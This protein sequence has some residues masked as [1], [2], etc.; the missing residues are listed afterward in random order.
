MKIRIYVIIALF[1]LEFI[2]IPLFAVLNLRWL[3]SFLHIALLFSPAL[4]FQGFSWKFE[5]SR[6]FVFWAM[7]AFVMTIA[8]FLKGLPPSV[9]MAMLASLFAPLVLPIL[10]D[11]CSNKKEHWDQILREVL[12]II[13]Y[14]GT[15]YFFAEWIVVSRLQLIS[16]CQLASYLANERSSQFCDTGRSMAV[17]FFIYKDMSLAIVMGAFLSFT[18]WANSRINALRFFLLTF[19]MA[20]VDSITLSGILLFLL[21][22]RFRGT[23]RSGLALKLLFVLIT[24]NLFVFSSSYGR[25]IGY[26]INELNLNVFL[27]SLEGCTWKNLFILTDG[28]SQTCHSREMHSLFYLFKFGLMA[29][30]SWYFTLALIGWKFLRTFFVD[31][32]VPPILFF[33]VVFLLNAVHYSGAEGWGV[34]YFMFVVLFLC[35]LGNFKNVSF[36]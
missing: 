29:T 19:S 3:G 13:F 27:P 23:L 2:R 21:P 17:G 24:L 7:W 25:I 30:L 33:P 15:L 28:E 10:I 22:F 26:F 34:N 32:N 20:V 11:V 8:L 9:Y 31:K 6:Y 1:I 18:D 12:R 14:V 35:M 4:L 5:R 16:Q 36:K